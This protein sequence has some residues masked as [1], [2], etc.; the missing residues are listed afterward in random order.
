[1]QFTNL[2]I[3]IC[4]LH[5]MQT[6]QARAMFVAGAQYTLAAGNFNLQIAKHRQPQIMQLAV[7]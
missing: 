5:P 1:M 6:V 2:D 3:E 4:E 7:P